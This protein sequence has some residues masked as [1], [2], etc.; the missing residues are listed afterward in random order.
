MYY[1]QEDDIIL[2]QQYCCI[3]WVEPLSVQDQK[4]SEK[5]FCFL[6][7]RVEEPEKL[8]YEKVMEDYR[9]YK[10]MYYKE[11][12]S[13]FECAVPYVKIRGAY[14]TQEQC[15][16]R[17]KQLEDRYKDKEP[18]SI[19]CGL[20]GKWFPYLANQKSSADPNL[21]MLMNKA[22]YNYQEHIREAEHEFKEHTKK[23]Q[24]PFV[25]R[26]YDKFKDYL[27][28]DKVI[29]RYQYFCVSFFH[30][31]EDVE[32]K[33]EEAYITNFLYFFLSEEFKARY[34]KK[35]ITDIPDFEDTKEGLWSQFQKSVFE[36]KEYENHGWPCFKL[37]GVYASEEEA[38]KRAEVLQKKDKNYRV[39]VCRVGGW[40]PFNPP[41]HLLKSHYA[42]EELDNIMGGLNQE[43]DH[44]VIQNLEELHMKSKEAKE[45]PTDDNVEVL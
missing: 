43:I 35:G 30:P 6:K 44:D 19:Y 11:I 22:L 25:K 18:V 29:E 32:Q 10:E 5:L 16:Q 17:I 23:E 28:E 39:D 38:Q 24:T 3:S 45:Q 31:K 37:R 27:D 34:S 1:M 9:D 33:L 26:P 21:P 15:I 14:K 40:L 7:S 12:V 36:E 20:V 13:N 8:S 2:S 4:V 41:G 42:D